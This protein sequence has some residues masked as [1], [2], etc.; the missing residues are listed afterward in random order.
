MLG[1]GWK[2]RLGKVAERVWQ[3]GSVVGATPQ[4]V[5]EGIDGPSGNEVDKW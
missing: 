1:D 3:G 2:S 5:E 4:E